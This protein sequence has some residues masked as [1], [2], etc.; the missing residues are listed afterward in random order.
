MLMY[1]SW[2]NFKGSGLSQIFRWDCLT[3]KK[4]HW[5][6][7]MNTVI[8]VLQIYSPIILL[9]DLQK[10]IS[11]VL[12]LLYSLHG[13]A[14]FATYS[15]WATIYNRFTGFISHFNVTNFTVKTEA[16]AGKTYSL[17]V[18]CNIWK[19]SIINFCF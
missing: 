19:S 14:S 17:S 15:S 7:K 11:E 10:S 13:L 8:C 12:S 2:W 18:K 5:R 4:T 1:K 6:K 3:W 9:W 16:A